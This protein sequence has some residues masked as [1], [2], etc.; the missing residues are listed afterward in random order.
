[1]ADGSD[2]LGLERARGAARVALGPGGKLL[3]LG[4][5]GSA[6]AFLPRVHGPVPEVVFLNTSGGLTGG[7]RLSFAVDLAPGVS[8]L[9]T[10]QTAERAYASAGG[11]AQ[12]TVDLSLGAGATLD[13]LP[14]ETILFDRSALSRRTT[15]EIG[16]GARLMLA[17]AVVLGRAA[18]GER[19]AQTTLCD[20]REVRREGRPVFLEPLRLTGATLGAGPACLGPHR[21]AATLALVAQGAEDA[22]GPVRDLLSTLAEVEAAASGWD[23]RL[24]VRIMAADAF[25]L[26]R[27]MAAVVMATGRAL[28]RV[29]QI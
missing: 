14:Q 3:R 21:A 18:M 16:P 29:W 7:D 26:K 5:Q 17:E 8:A 19:V 10:T 15:A 2:L 11:G 1:M 22:L 9:A 12:V 4:Q 28:P 25:P 6:K 24:I 13:W 23:G 27:A 20:W